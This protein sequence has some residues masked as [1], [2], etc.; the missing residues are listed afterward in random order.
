M[1]GNKPYTFPECEIALRCNACMGGRK[2]RKKMFFQAQ[3]LS[4][5]YGS[6]GVVNAMI[7]NQST[8]AKNKKNDIYEFWN[9]R[10]ELGVEAG[11]RDTVCKR[12][13]I[14]A[15]AGYVK[16]GMN[17]LDAGCGNGVTALELAECYAVNVTGFDF[18]EKMIEAAKEQMANK[19]LKGN[20]TF[21][22]HE[23]KNVGELRKTY[24]L[25]Y[26]ERALIN[27]R[28]WKEQEEAIKSIIGLLKPDARYLMCENSQDALNRLNSIRLQA[29]LDTIK[30]PWHNR[31]LIEDEIQNIPVAGAELEEIENFASTYYFLSRVVNAWLSKRE[32]REPAYDAPINKLALNLP[33]IG[34]VGQTKL[35]V[36]KKTG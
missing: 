2:I 12:L 7:S 19:R 28:S 18:A 22:V 21:F 5:R 23:L 34:D 13:E 26:T 10:S 36:W 14:E 9:N 8:T 25:V 35:W 24:D 1:C 31:Y 15:I 29:G 3:R 16:D 17:I 30:P 32:G 11:T 33:P 27:F 4:S 20:C 6:G